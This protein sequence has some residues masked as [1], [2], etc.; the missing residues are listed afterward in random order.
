M[1]DRDRL[2]RDST[3]D[4]EQRAGAVL[5]QDAAGP[6]DLFGRRGQ[7]ALAPEARVHRHQEQ[8]VDVVEHLG[9][10]GERRAGVQGQPREHPP[11]TNRRQLPLHVDRRFRVKGQHRRA[12]RRHRLDVMLRLGP[13]RGVDGCGVIQN[14]ACG[15]TRLCP[16]AGAGRSRFH[17]YRNFF[18]HSVIRLQDFP[19]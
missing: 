17:V 1:R 6:G 7:V 10:V 19:E 16:C 14:R 12:R 18:D 8:Q 3:V 11:G 9:G 13:C 2:G 15:I 5:R 4:F